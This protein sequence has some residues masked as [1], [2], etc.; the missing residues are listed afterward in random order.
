MTKYLNKKIPKTIRKKLWEIK[1]ESTNVLSEYLPVSY[2]EKIHK[3]FLKDDKLLPNKAMILA[4]KYG[5]VEMTEPIVCIIPYHTRKV[6]IDNCIFVTKSGTYNVSY[7][8]AGMKVTK[9]SDEKLIY[10]LPYYF[11]GQHTLLLSSFFDN[12][13]YKYDGKELTPYTLDFKVKK[14]CN[15]FGRVFAISDFYKIRFSDDL[16]PFNWN[17]SITE[18]GYIEFDINNGLVLNLVSFNQYLYVFFE[19]GL[20]RIS[21]YGDQSEFS[22]KPVNI[23]TGSV[24]DYTMRNAGDRLIFFSTNGLNVFDG[25][26]HKVLFPELA[27]GIDR[28]YYGDAVYVDNKYYLLLRKE[29]F[30]K[31]NRLIIYDLLQNNYSVIHDVPGN[32]LALLGLRSI[33]D[34]AVYQ[35]ETYQTEVKNTYPVHYLDEQII[36]ELR[37]VVTNDLDFGYPTKHKLLKCITNGGDV[38]V[39]LNLTVDG[40]LYTYDIDDKSTQLINLKGVTFQFDITTFNQSGSVLPPIVEYQIL[41]DI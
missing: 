27:E 16:N 30:P 33:K 25:Y 41:G 38:A 6:Y 34:V 20:M 24:M 36:Q 35:S 32:K 37:Q 12:I 15:H 5:T 31:T 22:V 10:G 13:Y 39:T 8:V 3:Y 4:Y 9:I 28:N 17:T 18:G 14:F 21:A 7:T 23:S 11:E 40:K 1:G 19:H 2:V 29:P 26:T